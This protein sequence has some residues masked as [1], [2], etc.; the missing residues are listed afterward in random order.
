[1]SSDGASATGPVLARRLGLPDATLVVVGGIV[2]AGIFLNPSVVARQMASPVWILAA[3]AAGGLVALMGAWIYAELGSER[4]EAGGQYVY[5]REAY[6]PAV[7]FLYGWGLLWVI[8]SGGMAA[9]AVTF[10]MYARGLM[11]WGF[12]DRLIAV[13]ALLGL[14][15]INCL[16]VRA[17]A[18]TQSALTVLKSL[19]IAGLIAAGLLGSVSALPAPA[20]GSTPPVP[21][22]DLFLLL[23]ALVPVLFAYG[24]WQT[25]GFLAGE[26]RDPARTLP[27]ALVLGITG[28]IT[29]Y[30][31]TNLACLRALGPEALAATQTPAS[32]VMRRT[33]G[34]PGARWIAVGILVSTLGFLSQGMLT[35]PRVYFAMARDR[36]FFPWLA[37]VHPTSRVPVPAI[38]LQG[39]VASVIAC[40]GRY[41]TILNYVVSVDF[42]FFGLAGVC[43][44]LFRRRPGS[45]AGFRV[46]GHPWTTLAFTAIC[47]LV[48]ADLVRRQPR[49]SLI[50]LGILAAGLPAYWFW[51]PR[52]TPTAGVTDSRG[53]ADAPG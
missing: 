50:G 27:R 12:D 49:D 5:F 44:F 18:T 28:V 2:G 26:V 10:A 46:P 36:L 45:H 34:E 4:P 22:G 41:E 51:R 23:G 24:G 32:D 42:V 35:A 13:T 21:E 25:A 47:W 11:G 20:S 53:G 52:G 30:L 7:A 37:R 38:V 39:G 33:L 17:G 3:W 14:T 29:L 9:V 1:M 8:Q 15:G 16:G 48:V 43:V 31:A 19:A 40:T 6:H